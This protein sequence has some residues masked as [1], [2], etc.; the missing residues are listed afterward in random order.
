VIPIPI[1]GG[2]IA[3]ALGTAFAAFTYMGG[4]QHASRKAALAEPSASA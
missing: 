3:V 4:R 2:M 1:W